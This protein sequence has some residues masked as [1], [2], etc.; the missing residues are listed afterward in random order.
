MPNGTLDWCVGFVIQPRTGHILLAR[1]H[2]GVYIGSLAPYGGKLEEGETA[3]EA[4][5]RELTEECGLVACAMR[6]VAVMCW[7]D[8][9]RTVVRTGT[10]FAVTRWRG[11]PKSTPTMR[12]PRWCSRIELPARFM[13]PWDRRW[14]RR[15]V[16]DRSHIYAV[17]CFPQHR[18]WRML[19]RPY[20]AQEEVR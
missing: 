6:P 3:E 19:P 15:A 11:T 1:K 2:S 5:R 13:T 12:K 18:V 10:C 17:D 14:V 20:E 8:T 9:R 16:A 7:Y 4:I